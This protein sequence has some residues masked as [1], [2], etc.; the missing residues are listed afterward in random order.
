MPGLTFVVNHLGGPP[1][2][3]GQ[4]ASS[5]PWASAIRSVAE[6]PNVACKLSGMHTSQA[7]AAGLRPYYQTAL[8]AFGPARL[9]LGTDWPVSALTAPYGQVCGMYRELTA[10]LSASEH[11]AIFGGTARR[12]YRLP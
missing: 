12:V 5:G 3:T 2:G 7:D 8:S 11:Q 10:E 6:L 1:A 9:L 4:G